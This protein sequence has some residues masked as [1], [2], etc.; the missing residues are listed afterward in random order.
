MTGILPMIRKRSVK[1]KG[2]ATSVSLEDE[3][4]SELRRIAQSLKLSVAELIERVDAG[5]TGDN[6]SSAL[7]LAVLADLKARVEA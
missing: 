5:R 3:Y 4:W 1:L 7:R 2:H 6:L